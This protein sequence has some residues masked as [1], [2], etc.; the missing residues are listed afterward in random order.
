MTEQREM[1]NDRQQIIDNRR[2]HIFGSPEAESAVICGVGSQAENE[3][4]DTARLLYES[5]DAASC[6]LLL[7]ETADW[8]GDFSPWP[9]EAVFGDEPFAGKAQETLCWLTGSLLPYLERGQLL[10]VGVK[11]YLAGYSLS[12]LFALWAFL[13]TALLY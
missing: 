8:N 13:E 3:L 7:F 11:K 2:C 5:A 6:R 12:V 1:L 9:S 10:A 4:T